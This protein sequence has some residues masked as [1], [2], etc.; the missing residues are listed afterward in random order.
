MVTSMG[1]G[2]ATITERERNA[3]TSPTYRIGRLALAA[4]VLTLT[5]LFGLAGLAS[6]ATAPSQPAAAANHSMHAMSDC[7]SGCC[8]HPQ[9]CDD[10][11]GMA[12]LAAL[13][14]LASTSA[15]HSG[16]CGCCNLERCCNSEGRATTAPAAPVANND[17][18]SCG[19][20]CDRSHNAA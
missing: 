2:H 6:A 11:P 14:R 17:S 16:S 1:G 5:A 12:D 20:C 10:M 19:A 18:P 7:P 8:G 3:M 4:G 9:C 15:R 13:Q